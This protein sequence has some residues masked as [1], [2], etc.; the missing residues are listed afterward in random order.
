MVRRSE[1]I[2][3]D[4]GNDDAGGAPEKLWR[5]K[6]YEAKHECKRR[7]GDYPGNRER[8][9]YAPERLEARR[10]E[11]VRGLHQITWDVFE[12]RV[13]RKKCKGRVDVG[14][15]QHNRKR[16]IEQELQWVAG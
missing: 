9:D 14:Q 11:V 10:A 1:E 12:G 8:K 13:N 3:D 5:E 16:A 15:R 2:Y 7:P 4:G 6:V